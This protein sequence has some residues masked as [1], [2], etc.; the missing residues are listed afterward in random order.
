MDDARIGALFRAIRN[1]RG[2]R[3]VDVAA[4][5]G[6]SQKQVSVAE[7]GRFD[8]MTVH[9]VRKLAAAYDV[10]LPFEPRWSR[11]DPVALLDRDHAALVNYV[12]ALLRRIGWEVLVEYTFNRYGERG[13]VDIVA[14]HADMRA[15]LI[16][17]VKPRVTDTQDTFAGL[18]R[19]ERIVPALLA[20]ERG[21]KADAFAILLV[22]V[23]STANRAAVARH[24]SSFGVAL[25]DRARAVRAWLRRP[26][27]P[28]RGVWFVSPRGKGRPSIAP[29][30]RRVRRPH[31][32]ARDA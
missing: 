13:S 26:V 5:A 27:G 32:P 10:R 14:W 31:S 20:R 25:P 11:G 19:K 28:L 4:T 7:A 3:Q 6:M 15:L 18:S 30:F 2:W 23:G 29:R 8:E 9:A 12:V 21:W 16:I 1:R 22:T 24:A 17:E